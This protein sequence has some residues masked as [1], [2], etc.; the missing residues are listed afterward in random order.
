MAKF[1]KKLFFYADGRVIKAKRTD[2]GDYKTDKGLS[3][4]APKTK[5]IVYEGRVRNAFRSKK[6]IMTYLAKVL[7]YA[8]SEEGKGSDMVKNVNGQLAPTPIDAQEY[9]RAC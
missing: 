5:M 9:A 8:T 2:R 1:P 4:Y 3:P 7:G 6:K